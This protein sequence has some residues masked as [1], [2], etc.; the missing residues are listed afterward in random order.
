MILLLLVVDDDAD[1]DA[2]AVITDSFYVCDDVA[3]T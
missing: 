2:D 3:M 1:A